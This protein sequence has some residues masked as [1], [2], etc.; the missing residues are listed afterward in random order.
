MEF[1]ANLQYVVSIAAGIIIV[2]ALLHTP[3]VKTKSNK[4]K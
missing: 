3:K 1:L 4:Y 2:A